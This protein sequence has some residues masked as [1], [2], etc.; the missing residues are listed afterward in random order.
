[1]EGPGKWSAP[2]P[3]LA[4]GRPDGIIF[5]IRNSKN[6]C[7]VRVGLLGA[8]MK[9]RNTCLNKAGTVHRVYS[10]SLSC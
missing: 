4:L 1:M 6:S 3:A 9:I 7:I 8:K 2:G 10:M 5:S